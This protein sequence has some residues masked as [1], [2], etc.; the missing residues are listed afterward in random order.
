MGVPFLEVL[1]GGVQWNGRLV[2]LQ[3][4][5]LCGVLVAHLDHMLVLIALDREGP[6]LAFGCLLLLWLLLANHFPLLG[7]LLLLPFLLQVGHGK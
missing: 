6:P 1:D 2:H 7:Y 5:V 4:R 3:P